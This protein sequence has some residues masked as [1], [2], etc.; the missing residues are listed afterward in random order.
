MELKIPNR[1][2]LDCFKKKAEF[3][4]SKSNPQWYPLTVALKEALLNGN[5]DKVQELINKLLLNFV[6]IRD[7]AHEDFYHGFL[8]GVLS[9][10]L[11]DETLKS[12]TESGDGYADLLLYSDYLKIAAIL[13]F[14]KVAD[15]E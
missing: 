3:I 11:D 5:Q 14:K 8:S 2:I 10:A 7:S 4:F 6:S 15:G 1:E 12:D 9:V 13:E